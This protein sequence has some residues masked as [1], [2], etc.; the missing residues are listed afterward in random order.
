MLKL[1]Y[2]DVLGVE[3]RTIYLKSAFISG[4]V[5]ITLAALWMHIRVGIN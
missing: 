5:L 4:R 2:F 3:H 1:Q